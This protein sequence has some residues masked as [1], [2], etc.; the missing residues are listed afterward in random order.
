[1]GDK[2]HFINHINKLPDEVVKSAEFALLCRKPDEAINILLQN[3]R[4][5]RAIKMYMRLH[6]W[7]DALDLAVAQ[8]THVDTV[9]ATGPSTS[10]TSSTKRVTRS[11]SRS[12]SR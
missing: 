11:S 10:P 3:K 5:Y 8:K 9:L 7:E 6:R 4:I 2:V 12:R 1:M